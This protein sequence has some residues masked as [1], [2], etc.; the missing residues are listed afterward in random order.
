MPNRWVVVHFRLDGVF[1]TESDH[2]TSDGACAEGQA[3]V[4]AMPGSYANIIHKVFPCPRG[5]QPDEPGM[6][7]SW[8]TKVIKT[9]RS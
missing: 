5:Y 6:K 4:D 8:G 3:L 2:L 1:N 7:D 9:I